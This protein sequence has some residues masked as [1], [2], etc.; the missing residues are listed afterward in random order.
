MCFTDR[1]ILLQYFMIFFVGYFF[2]KKILKGHLQVVTYSCFIK[3]WFLIFCLL[4][5]MIY[6]FSSG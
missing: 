4:Q 6:V 1:K 5:E 3:Y 2:C